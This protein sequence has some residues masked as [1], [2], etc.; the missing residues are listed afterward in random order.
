LPHRCPVNAPNQ[1]CRRAAYVNNAVEDGVTKSWVADVG[2]PFVH[3][4]LAG[5]DGGSAAVAVVYDLQQIT[6][7]FAG[8]RRQSP[9]IEDEDLHAGQALEHAGVAPV[10]ACEAKPFQHAWHALIEHL[11]K[12]AEFSLKVG[13]EYSSVRQRVCVW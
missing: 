12:G 11:S 6:P 10:T 13:A 9:I 3:W 2:M 4:E 1:W 7:L 8:Q 5:D